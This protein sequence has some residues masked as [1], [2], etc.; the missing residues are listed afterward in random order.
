MGLRPFIKIISEG[1]TTF[2]AFCI[3]HFAFGRQSVKQQ[4]TAASEAG[5][6]GVP[7]FFRKAGNV[8]WWKIYRI[9]FIM[10]SARNTPGRK[11]D[12]TGSA[13]KSRGRKR[14]PY[15]E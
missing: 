12:P 3:L 7:G 15:E 5:R 1:N 11:A 6:V 2:F 8:F 14:L 4:F 9:Y 10:G 13:G